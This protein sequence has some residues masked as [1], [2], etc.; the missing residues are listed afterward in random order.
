ME[1]IDSI[2]LTT[3]G[4][5]PARVTAAARESLGAHRLALLRGMPPDVDVLVSVLSGLGTLIDNYAAGSDSEAYALHRAVN[6]VRYRPDSAA[7]RVQERD[8]ALPM[9]SGRAF[10]ADRPRYM[11]MQMIDPGWSDGAAG[12]NGESLLVRW[13]EVLASM[14]RA[15]PDGFTEDVRT[16]TTKSICFP[17]V[18]LQDEAS[19]LPLV[20]VP[21]TPWRESV[22]YDVAA[23]LPQKFAR[24]EQC[25]P[26]GRDG[27][28]FIRAA[29]RFAEHADTPGVQMR[30]ALGAGDLVIIDNDRFGHGRCTVRGHRTA[31]DGSTSVNPR[32]L[33]SVNVA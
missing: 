2:A 25:A 31:E 20:Y 7:K 3:D 1:K 14:E 30:Y 18:N 21:P 29:R 8:G 10:A 15:D 9:H 17:S 19:R 4:M 28:R 33:W 27:D 11:A 24:L 13:G 12:E 5:S 16:L 6:V 22:R 23:R 32:T 26:P